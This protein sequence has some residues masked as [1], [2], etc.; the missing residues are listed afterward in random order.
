MF[1]IKIGNF[2]KLK[3]H[4]LKKTLSLPIVYSKSGHE[5]GKDI[6]RTRTN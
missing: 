4:I 1:A 6:Q 2:K 5:Y 3:N